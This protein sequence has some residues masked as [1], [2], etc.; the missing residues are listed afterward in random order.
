MFN[1]T[2]L[3]IDTFV[4]M[5]KENYERIYGLLDPEFANI[6][7]FVGRVALENIANTN[8]AYHD[9]NH[10]IMVTQV[11][12][13]ILRGKH[14]SEGGVTTS[15][16]MN[17][18]ISLLCHDVGYVRG[19]LRGDRH[20]SYVKNLEGDMVEVDDGA[21]DAAMTPYHVQRS[22]LFVR[23]RFAAN[24]H[25]DAAIIEANILNT[26]FPVPDGATSEDYKD[27][28]SL[29]RAA[30]LIGQL[31]DIGYERKQAALFHEFQETGTADVLGFKSPGDL[32]NSYP[33]FFWGAV[34]PYINDALHYLSVTQEGKQWIANLF[35]HVF[36]QE[37]G[38]CGLG[39]LS[40]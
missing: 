36:A 11:G 1:P 5:L 12:Q 18:V 16:W 38:A 2:T 40:D 30:D 21:T 31:A 20:G 7:R 23:E 10:T 22:Q 14:L 28:P 24:P 19:I 8:A 13:E 25:I 4:E 34:S 3:V 6:T 37:H 9:V 35:A 27:Y 15:D 29:L 26:S 32:R 39:P 17:F 33:Q